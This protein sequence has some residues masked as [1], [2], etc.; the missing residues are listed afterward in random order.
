MRMAG[1]IVG[2]FVVAIA[3]FGL[4]VFYNDM[5]M[6]REAQSRRMRARQP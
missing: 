4:G 2:A 3:F 6:T 1:T 5:R